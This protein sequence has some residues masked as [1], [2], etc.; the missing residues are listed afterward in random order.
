[1]ECESSFVIEVTFNGIVVG[2]VVMVM[3]AGMTVNDADVT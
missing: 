3:V 2:A 1:V